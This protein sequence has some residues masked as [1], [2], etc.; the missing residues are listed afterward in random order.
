M[1]V[2][3]ILDFK[4]K[5]SAFVIFVLVF[6]AGLHKLLDKSELKVSSGNAW[7]RRE[8]AAKWAKFKKSV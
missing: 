3:V 5:R 4:W 6:R 2:K 1:A 7:K 8:G